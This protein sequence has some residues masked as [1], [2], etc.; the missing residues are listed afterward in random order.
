TASVS[1]RQNGDQVVF[2]LSIPTPTESELA[3]CND[4][5]ARREQEITAFKQAERY[6]IKTKDEGGKPIEYK[7]TAPATTAVPVLKQAL[8]SCVNF[9]ENHQRRFFELVD[10]LETLQ[11]YGQE[12]SSASQDVIDIILSDAAAVHGMQALRGIEARQ[13]MYCDEFASFV[14]TYQGEGDMRL[15]VAL[16][17]VMSNTSQNDLSDKFI[18]LYLNHVKRTTASQLESLKDLPDGKL[19]ERTIEKIASANTDDVY[20]V[21]QALEIVDGRFH[22]QL[23][24]TIAASNNGHYA[25]EALGIVDGKL[26]APLVRAIAASKSAYYAC[27]AL[28]KVSPDYHSSLVSAIVEAKDKYYAEQALEVVKDTA[29]QMQ[30]QKIA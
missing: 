18:E 29:L 15:N 8:R 26:H 6:M 12:A 10:V 9:P 23:V 7:I 21:H 22:N 2:T 17:Y 28:S 5:V 13:G 11:V 24:E 27:E 25:Y 1:W 14:E 3:R 19:K 4:Y 16:E 30:L 20:Y